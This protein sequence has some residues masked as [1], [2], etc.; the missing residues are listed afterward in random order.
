M[1]LDP[2]GPST[3]DGILKQFEDHRVSDREIVE[4]CTFPKIA[5]MEVDVATVCEADEPV[6]LP[7]PQPYD[8]AG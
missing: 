3:A 7:D 1:P 4:R 5:P 6:A 2:R 8:A